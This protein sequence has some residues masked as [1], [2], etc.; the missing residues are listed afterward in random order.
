MLAFLHTQYVTCNV[1]AVQ[2]VN[3]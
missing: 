3:A 1:V 2:S